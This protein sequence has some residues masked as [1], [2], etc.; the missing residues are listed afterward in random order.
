MEDRSFVD[1]LSKGNLD[2]IEID[3][4]LIDSFRRVMRKIQKF[5][6]DRGYTKERNYRKFL[7]DLL[8][9]EG[10][11]KYKI[12][13]SK[14][15]S[16]RKAN[17]L[18]SMLQRRI[19]IN[20]SIL[21]DPETLDGVLCHE[22]I[23]FLVVAG[24]FYDLQTDKEALKTA[25]MNEALTQ[26]LTEAIMQ[27]DNSAVY[28]PQT[29]MARF[30]RL[31]KGDKESYSKFLKGG[32]DFSNSPSSLWKK[33]MKDAERYHEN[34]RNSPY[35][36][37]EAI[38]DKDYIAAQRDLITDKTSTI[39]KLLFWEYKNIVELLLERPAPD[40]E[41]MDKFF[42]ELDESY[43]RKLGIYNKD[44]IEKLKEK[45]KEFRDALEL[46]KEVKDNEI[47]EF[48]LCGHKFFIDR[49]G[50]IYDKSNVEKTVTEYPSTGKYIVEVAGEK[51]ELDMNSLKFSSYKNKLQQQQAELES[52]FVSCIQGDIH[53]VAKV[54]DRDGLIKLERFILPVENSKAVYIA[55]YKDHI[56]ILTPC[57]KL[58]TREHVPSYKYLGLTHSD[59]K[60]AII[61]AEP[62][63]RE[64][65]G[66]IYSMNTVKTLEHKIITPMKDHLRTTLSKNQKENLI[67]AYLE[68]IDTTE[69][70]ILSGLLLE[71]QVL[72][73]YAKSQFVSLSEEEKDDMYLELMKRD[74]RFIIS[75]DQ[76]QIK[77]ST[78]CG[79]EFPMAYEST[80]VVLLDTNGKGLYNEMKSVIER[81]PSITE[82]YERM[83]LRPY[84]GISKEIDEEQRH[85]ETLRRAQELLNVNITP[86]AGFRFDH[87]DQKIPRVIM[88]DRKTLQE[89]KTSTL[90][91]LRDLYDNNIL[92]S[93]T[94]LE[95]R[96]ALTEEY[97]RWEEQAEDLPQTTHQQPK[98]R[99]KTLLK[100]TKN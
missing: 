90:G 78:F 99:P 6:N 71:N 40:D 67:R 57:I 42:N 39:G 65:S 82:P 98:T 37:A 35:P 63:N 80:P 34:P 91:Q 24:A 21:D 5:F 45:L 61:F 92:N 50:K 62:Q 7:Q 60:K 100:A 81:K 95:M 76:G 85:K 59:P 41:Y 3:P 25:F 44:I 23:H 86:T 84:N 69:E 75:F 56:E 74:T 20:E 11:G 13:V 79:D 53:A 51:I 30:A 14:E 17:G 1:L 66:T 28:K 4:R 27:E 49:N 9:K 87:P 93:T 38:K 31:L 32:I 94:Y 2:K 88:K 46:E 22:F 73:D 47:Y 16:Q 72:F 83:T 18:F 10:T 58:G 8:L 77:V 55:T 97:K 54:K 70:E 43:I 36:F 15:L 68:T 29:S 12:V 19:Y 52:I 64:L 33:F 96:R 48:E 26:M 89:E